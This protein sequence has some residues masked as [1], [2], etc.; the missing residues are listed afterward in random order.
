[1]G[2]KLE[3]IQS[4]L[5]VGPFQTPLHRFILDCCSQSAMG[6]MSASLR[7]FL[8]SPFDDDPAKM[9]A[10]GLVAKGL[11]QPIEGEGAVKEV[12]FCY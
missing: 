11:G 2:G 7:E 9:D 12:T 4:N 6:Q 8:A 3:S 5:Q 10:A 1:M